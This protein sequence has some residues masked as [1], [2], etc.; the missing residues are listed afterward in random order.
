M[1]YESFVRTNCNENGL[2][3]S[4]PRRRLPRFVFSDDGIRQEVGNRFSGFA[5]W[6][7]YS[8]VFEYVACTGTVATYVRR[9]VRKIDYS[10]VDSCRLIP[11][12]LS[13]PYSY[14]S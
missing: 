2:S 3:K 13:T 1:Q 10:F 8:C 5:F 11:G 6:F 7:R 14:I 4:G 9:S 12:S